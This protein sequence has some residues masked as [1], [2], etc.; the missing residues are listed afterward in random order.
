MQTFNEPSKTVADP[1][2]GMQ[3]D[4]ERYPFTSTYKGK[5]YH[6]CSETCLNKFG[7]DADGFVG[8]KKEHKKGWWARYLEK[9][10]KQEGDIRSCCH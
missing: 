10:K 4:P 5:P 9:L 3:I 7:D 2:C 6:F 1:V 8:Q